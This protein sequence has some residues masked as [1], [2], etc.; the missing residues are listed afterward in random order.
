MDAG[1]SWLEWTVQTAVRQATAAGFATP[2]G[3]DVPPQAARMSFPGIGAGWERLRSPPGDFWGAIPRFHP[4]QEDPNPRTRPPHR[5]RSTRAHTF[6]APGSRSSDDAAQ[7]GLGGPAPARRW[8][9]PGGGPPGRRARSPGVSRAP[10]ARCRAP[11]VP[12]TAAPAQ[13]TPGDAASQPPSPF[14]PAGLCARPWRAAP[15]ASPRL[16]VRAAS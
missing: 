1:L 12:Q 8:R 7:S 4:Q 15:G 16:Q 3:D 5:A 10:R 9:F 2:F 11:G 6:L 14:V 13:P